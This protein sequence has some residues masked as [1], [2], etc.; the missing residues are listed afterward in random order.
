MKRNNKTGKM[1]II[2]VLIDYMEAHYII[3][4]FVLLCGKTFLH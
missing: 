2:A 1:L 4:L 3:L